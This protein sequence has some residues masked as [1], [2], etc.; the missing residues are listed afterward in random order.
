MDSIA[1]NYAT[2]QDLVAYRKVDLIG[3]LFQDSLMMGSIDP[4]I[5]DTTIASCV[6]RTNVDLTKGSITLRIGFHTTSNFYIVELVFAEFG[7]ESTL[8]VVT[9]LYMAD[10]RALNEN[11]QVNSKKI[12]VGGQQEW[13]IAIRCNQEGLNLYTL[14]YVA[15]SIKLSHLHDGTPTSYV[16]CIAGSNDANGDSFND[17]TW[18]TI[19]DPNDITNLL[20][21]GSIISWCPS[22]PGYYARPWD[23]SLF[24]GN[25]PIWLPCDGRQ[26][27]DDNGETKT[28]PDLRGRFLMG[29]GNEVNVPT[30]LGLNGNIT[31]SPTISDKE[32]LGIFNNDA[33][34]GSDLP[35]KDQT[36]NSGNVNGSTEGISREA[37]VVNCGK[38]GNK[39]G[40]YLTKLLP[41]QQGSIVVGASIGGHGDR[42]HDEG[43]FIENL[44]FAWSP[45]FAK[46]DFKIPGKNVTSS[47]GS[48][49]IGDHKDI[50]QGF[51]PTS[52]LGS[53][54]CQG[55]VGT[56]WNKVWNQMTY[57]R[58][59]LAEGAS[60]H[61]NKPPYV[62][63][64]Y[65]IKVR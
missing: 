42:A 8:H 39:G 1:Q 10:G 34:R 26:Y 61:D 28:T 48:S 13:N 27:V 6:V 40:S 58:F 64:A 2:E 41:K 4:T 30:N 45:N 46:S 51:G 54:N 49:V 12:I 52:V 47:P 25:K 36:G 11:I 7:S 17:N 29:Y 5:T 14:S 15:E 65:I 37:G 22:D 59:Y 35:Y 32:S 60:P 23:H 57:G 62:V 21:I 63:M 33:P 18:I 50:N 38:I 24:T 55:A 20:P 19:T 31:V 43:H 56:I 16:T 44:T 53:S 3:D 9:K